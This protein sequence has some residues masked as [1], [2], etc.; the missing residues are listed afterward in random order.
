MNLKNLVCV[1][2]HEMNVFV[3]GSG[4]KTIVFLAGSGV[5]APVLEY[6]PLYEELI[7]M[8]RIV[9]VEKAGY[10]FSQSNT[11]VKRD[12]L[13]MVNESREA[14]KKVGIEPPYFLAAHSYSGLEA[15]YWANSF[16]EE[17]EA[18]LGLDMVT[19]RYALAQAAELS[20]EKKLAMLD[21]QTKMLGTLQRSK[22]WQKLLKNQTL[23]A[24]GVWNSGLLSDE[25][26]MLYKEL[27]YRNLCNT[28]V[29]DE[30]I[31]ATNNALLTERTGRMK[32]P[33]YM[34]ISNM[35][36]PLKKTTWLAENTA[37]AEDNGLQYEIAD[38][39]FLYVKSQGHIA[40]VWKAF[41]AA[42]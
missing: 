13:S 18:V 26:K 29:R 42:L 41:A 31:A 8:F 24:S 2:G 17:V 23:N 15:V 35:K 14:L 38:S 12:I 5:T 20:E 11:G 33:G 4:V 10:G 40:S 27:F 39:H 9:V 6:K 25:E 19:P 21:R 34:F 3:T 1:N 32:V 28:E 22:F 36:T 7:D 30:Q 37:F 16:P